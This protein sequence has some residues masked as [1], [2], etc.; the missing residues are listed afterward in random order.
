MSLLTA[1]LVSAGFVT[2][3]VS[4]FAAALDVHAASHVVLF[5]SQGTQSQHVTS[6]HT[7]GEF[8]RERGIVPGPQ[9]YVH[10]NASTP[11]VDNLVVE[12]AA[13]VPVNIVTSA[14]SKRIITTATDVGALLEEQ[15][16]HLGP[17]DVVNPS[18]DDPIAANA[19]VRISRIVKWISREHHRVAQ[20]TIHEI[21][22]S[23]APGKT[24]VLKAGSPGETVT[25]VAYTQTDGKIRKRIVTRKTLRKPQP[26]VIAEGVGTQNAIA[27]FAQRGLEKM[28]YIASGALSMVATAYTAE[29]GG[30][31][32]YTA[33]GYR[34][35]HGIVAVDP[36]VIPLGTRLYIPGYGF[37]I[38]GDTGGAIV[39]HRIDL[40]FNS[41]ADA[42]QFGRR[43]VKVYTLH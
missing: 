38:A 31:S 41:I 29:C 11:L 10:P 33:T 15:G 34:A 12:Y 32:G 5:G 6:A 36:R 40:G 7:V 4:A 30:C 16:V 43:T 1:A 18:L 37:A 25:M 14:G 28:S 35:G 24:R 26:R 3:P 9:D 8:L 20:Q 17:H 39:G 22:F 13:A 19:T 21:D 2:H 23:L 42:M 27:D